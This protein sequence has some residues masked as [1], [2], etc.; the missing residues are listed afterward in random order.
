MLTIIN[1]KFA[2]IMIL[3]KATLFF[4]IISKRQTPFFILMDLKV[5]TTTI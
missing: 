5:W 4:Y 3:F 2:N 1:T